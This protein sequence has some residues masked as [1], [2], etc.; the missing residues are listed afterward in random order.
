MSLLLDALK[1]AE[2]NRKELE[3]TAEPNSP[4]ENEDICLDL[5][6]DQLEP[7][8]AD[9]D[10]LEP[11]ATEPKITENKTTGSEQASPQ[12]GMTQEKLLQ[13]QQP[14]ENTLE[15]PPVPATRPK[16]GNHPRIAA[17][18]FQNQA[19][20][21]SQLETKEKS[22]VLLLLL[23]LLLVLTGLIFI[24]FVLS[25]E[26]E[27]AFPHHRYNAQNK[28]SAQ[29]QETNS[30]SEGAS[31]SI[32]SKGS[33]HTTNNNGNQLSHIQSD[34][35]S[36]NEG[37]TILTSAAENPQQP[38]LSKNQSNSPV[39]TPPLFNQAVTSLGQGPTNF[40]NSDS[41]PNT[42]AVPK[43]GIQISKRKLS[44]Q[45]QSSLTAAQR[46]LKTGNLTSAEAA[47]R[48]AIKTSPENTTATSSLASLLAQ[49]GKTQ[50]AQIL[51]LKTLEKDPENLIAK[52]GLI[53]IRAKDS[54]NLSAGSQLK[55]LLT[56]YPKQAHLHASLGN[57]HARRNEW[58]A[59]Q[60]AYFEAFALDSDNP[61]YAFNLAI[62]LDQ[63][64]KPDIAA[65]YYKKAIELF[66]KHPSQFSKSDAERRLSELEGLKKSNEPN[67]LEGT[68]P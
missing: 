33:A 5:D 57:F 64:G 50:E 4:T 56:E 23:L 55:Q 29:V 24:Y 37:T 59:A 44:T 12:E 34:Q 40:P 1:E 22:R 65:N 54:T 48:Q 2:K 18:V 42:T 10:T 28:T 32:T 31:A 36:L 61:D 43:S 49:Q 13:K 38:Q 60:T 17:N 51:F 9:T 35:V 25:T 66:G 3:A 19:P 62:S 6:L 8:N 7:K 16:A 63:I 53:N 41:K 39:F 14:Q 67:Q 58:P 68:A 15:K 30:L 20:A 26:P 27:S 45:S 46:A 11:E 21:S 52:T 47:Y